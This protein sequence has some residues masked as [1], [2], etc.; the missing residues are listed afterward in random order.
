MSERLFHRTPLKVV[1]KKDGSQEGYC[2][3]FWILGIS[4]C[5]KGFT[6]CHAAVNHEFC[7]Y[8]F[9]AHEKEKVN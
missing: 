5:P 8:D 7:D 3:H 1:I 6:V 2:K 9:P 4:K